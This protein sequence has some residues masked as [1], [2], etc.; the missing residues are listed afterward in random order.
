VE[1]VQDKHDPEQSSGGV[2]RFQVL[3]TNRAEDL[4]V[5]QTDDRYATGNAPEEFR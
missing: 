3:L 1:T 2:E 5:I 4:A